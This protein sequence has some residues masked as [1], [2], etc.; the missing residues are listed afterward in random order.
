M[1]KATDEISGLMKYKHRNR[2]LKV[3]STSKTTNLNN[4]FINNS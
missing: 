4:S 3:P 1:L 2:K